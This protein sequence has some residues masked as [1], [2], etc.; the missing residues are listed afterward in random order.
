[1]IEPKIHDF[2]DGDPHV[3]VITRADKRSASRGWLVILNYVFYAAIIAVVGALVYYLYQ[4]RDTLTLFFPTLLGGAGTTIFLS[5]SSMILA[6]ITQV[7]YSLIGH[8]TSQ[9]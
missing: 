9:G 2:G 4:F 6:T 5:I 7:V 8:V 3:S 1:M